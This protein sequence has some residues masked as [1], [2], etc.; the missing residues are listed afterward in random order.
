M[1][2]P[3]GSATLRDCPGC[4]SLWTAST[5]SEFGNY[6]T[7]LAIQVLVVVTLDGGATEVGLVNA[8]RW[9]PYL[10]FGLIAGVLVDR[11]AHR[12]LLV[13]TDLGRGL[14]LIAVPMLALSHHLSLA[15]LMTLMVLFGLM[16]LLNDAAFQAIVA[17]L[18]PPNLLTDAHARLDQ[19]S[20]VA[21]TSGPALAGALVSALGAPWAVLVDAVSFVFSG[22]M[23]CGFR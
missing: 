22:L 2:G 13:T 6:F 10:L 11:Y 17:S 23:C 21:Q 12:P 18:V 15:V 16:S 4:V 8:S 5:V 20:A 3:G 9:L 14:L 1:S 19:S 7:T